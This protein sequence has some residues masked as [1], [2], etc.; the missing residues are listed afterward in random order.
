MW[1]GEALYALGVQGIG[2]L[3]LLGGFFS[4]KCGSSISAKFLI[5]GAHAVCFCPLVAM[6]DPPKD[7]EIFSYSNYVRKIKGIEKEAK[8]FH[9]TNNMILDSIHRKNLKISPKDY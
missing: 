7:P 2:V 8:L 9:F 4:V 3:L 6:L 1:H 5:C